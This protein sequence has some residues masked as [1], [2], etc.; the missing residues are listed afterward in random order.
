MYKVLNLSKCCY[1][2]GCIF[3]IYLILFDNELILNSSLKFLS[4]EN[5]RKPKPL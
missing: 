4:Y 1:I 2:Y 3:Y 5:K